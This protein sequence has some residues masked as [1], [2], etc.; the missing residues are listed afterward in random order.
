[1]TRGLDDW[2]LGRAE[3]G[4]VEAYCCQ[5]K[6]AMTVSTYTENGFTTWSPEECPDCGAEL[7]E[8]E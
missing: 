2:I 7:Q 4:A 3:S 8:A 6:E 1:M 5:C